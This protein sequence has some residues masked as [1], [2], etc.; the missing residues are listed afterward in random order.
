MKSLP[1]EPAADRAT[2]PTSIEAPIDRPP[3]PAAPEPAIIA[4]APSLVP[5]LEHEP[6]PE[7]AEAE[8]SDEADGFDARRRW[9]QARRKQ[10]RRA[11][12]WSAIILVL[13]A[14]NVALVGARNEVVRYL[15]QTASL[16]AVIGLPVNLRDLKFE[17]VKLA[18]ESKGGV[19]M[20]TV[21]GEIVSDADKPVAVPRL[22]FGLRNATGQEVYSWTMA[23]PRSILDP[24]GRLTFH[25]QI[26]TPQVDASDVMVRFLTARETGA[27]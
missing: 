15:P 4:D 22:H 25:S 27:K 1:A 9:L 5:Q 11:S 14:F 10:S 21:Q 3:E 8:D 20:L 12:G 23:P 2:P 24:G 16:F 6:L 26:P 7:S 19:D 18:S 17:H 13:L